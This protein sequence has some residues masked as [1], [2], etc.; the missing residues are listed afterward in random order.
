[1]AYIVECTYV[2]YVR[3]AWELVVLL[4]LVHLS[5]CCRLQVHQVH[6]VHQFD[7]G[8]QNHYQDQMPGRRHYQ[9]VQKS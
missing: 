4:P 8:L 2:I 9:T 3:L 6:Q 1:V 5:D 7:V